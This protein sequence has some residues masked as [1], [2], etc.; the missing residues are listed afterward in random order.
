MSEAD[1]AE[2]PAYSDTLVSLRDNSAVE[3]G[4][5]GVRVM[6]SSRESSSDDCWCSSLTSKFRSM[7]ESSISEP[8]RIPVKDSS[9][10]CD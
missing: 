10:I 4:I 8:D 3:V 1:D 5:V 7:S 2:G 9:L 6:M